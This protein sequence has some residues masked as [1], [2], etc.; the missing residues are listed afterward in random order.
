MF[1]NANA[2]LAAAGVVLLAL[3]VVPAPLLPPHRLA[4]AVQSMLGVG[5]KAAY[6]AAAVGLQIGFYG[7]LGVLAA[8]SVNGASTLRGRLLQIGVVPVAVVGVAVLIRSVK[9][10]HLPV[11]VNAAVPTAACLFG[12][13]L[14]LGLLYRRW[15]MTSLVAVAV[16]GVALWGLLGGTSAELSRDTEGHLRRLVKLWRCHHHPLRTSARCALGC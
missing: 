8:F 6:L 13:G 4:E 10:G 1:S 3:A 9:A 12:V 5:W 2:K 7:S 11:W 15:T 14:G 16:I